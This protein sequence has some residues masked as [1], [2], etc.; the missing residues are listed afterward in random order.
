M[1]TDNPIHTLIDLTK[2]RVGEAAQQLQTATT[3]R[4]GA[5]EQLATLHVYRQDY[6]ERFEKA[7]AE[8]MSAANYHNFRQFIATLDE[9]ISQQN[10]V[11]TQLDQKVELGK[12]RWLDQKRQLTSYEALLMRQENERR[13]QLNRKEQILNDEMSMHQYRRNQ[14]QAKG[15][16]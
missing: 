13:A 2:T 14:P 4:D 15:N 11:V 12:Q 6:I 10:R 5:Q 7:S 8:G 3:T 16:G 1:A 9:A